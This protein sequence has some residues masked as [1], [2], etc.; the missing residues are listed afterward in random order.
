MRRRSKPERGQPMGKTANIGGHNRSE[1]RVDDGGRQSLI[2]AELGGDLVRGANKGFGKFLYNDVARS[3]FVYRIEKAV[4]KADSDGLDVGVPQRTGCVAHR[5]FVDG[6]FDAPIMAQSFGHLEAQPP[7]YE[8]RW[9]V[10]L[11]IVKFGSFLPTYLQKISE[12]VTRDQT[13]QRASMLDESISGHR[14]SMAEIRDVACAH[15]CLSERFREPLCDRKRRIGG[16]RGNLPNRDTPALLVEQADI[17]EGAAGID[18]I[19]HAISE[20]FCRRSL[21]HNHWTQ[22][23][24]QS[25]AD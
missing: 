23:N 7:R 12:A 13:D 25:L 1:I 9:F 19:R 4:Q 16:G 20:P 3:G 2:F 8:H 24:A 18:P 17:G 6:R 21:A 11:Q 5:S 15:A 22:R 10:C 14:G